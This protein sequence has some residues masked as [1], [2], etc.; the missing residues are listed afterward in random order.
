MMYYYFFSYKKYKKK[1]RFNETLLLYLSIWK[2]NFVLNVSG[3]QFILYT[4]VQKER[5]LERSI[6]KDNLEGCIT[7]L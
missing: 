1:K 2:L 6:Q 7:V 5:S 3:L 4:I